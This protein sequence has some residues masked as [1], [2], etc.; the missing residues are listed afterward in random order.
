MALGPGGGRNVEVG[1]KT[2]AGVLQQLS[3]GLEIDFRSRDSAVSQIGREQWEFGSEIGSLSI[4]SQ[5][6]MDGE[7]VTQ[8]VDPRTWLAFGTPKADA[9]QE[10]QEERH[11][12]RM[13][14]PVSDDI[15]ENGR[16]EVRRKA[17]VATVA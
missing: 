17:G 15:Q 10:V 12:P 2:L 13:P 3:C 5:Q 1:V 8:V 16:D 4:P 6:A 14:V 9:P 11:E 7:R